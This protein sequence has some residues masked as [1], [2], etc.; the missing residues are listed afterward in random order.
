MI[1][2][3]FAVDTPFPDQTQRQALAAALLDDPHADNGVCDRFRVP[4]QAV[5]RLVA[6]DKVLGFRGSILEPFAGGSSVCSNF[7]L[8]PNDNL[9]GLVQA[10]DQATQRALAGET[11]PEEWDGVL[12]GVWAHP[13]CTQSLVACIG[14]GDWAS[15]FEEGISYPLDQLMWLAC[16]GNDNSPHNLLDRWPRG[17][18]LG[19][20]VR[21]LLMSAITDEERTSAVA[22]WQD[23]HPSLL[24]GPKAFRA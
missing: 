1:M 22:S 3:L 4:D 8:V 17:T 18:P 2:T 13:G 24:A 10:L 6:P 23:H 14:S 20:D 16:G 11:D 12:I 15:E 9:D 19:L 7:W 5:I 21:E